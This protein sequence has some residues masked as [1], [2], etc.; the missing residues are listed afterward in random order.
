MLPLFLALLITST[1]I[2]NNANGYETLPASVQQ[3]LDKNT[4]NANAVTSVPYCLDIHSVIV[5]QAP[6]GKPDGI[7]FVAEKTTHYL[8][9]PLESTW[10]EFGNWFAYS[11]VSQALQSLEPLPT[12]TV[13]ESRDQ[14]THTNNTTGI[15]RSSFFN[16]RG[17]PVERVDR[18]PDPCTGNAFLGSISKAQYPKDIHMGLIFLHVLA[19]K[20]VSSPLGIVAGTQT[21]QDYFKAADSIRH[22]GTETVLNEPCEVIEILI[23]KDNNASDSHTYWLAKNLN[24]II[25]RRETTLSDGKRMQSICRE[26]QEVSANV[27]IGTDYC[28]YELSLPDSSLDPIVEKLTTRYRLGSLEFDPT[29][30]PHANEKDFGFKFPENSIVQSLLTTPP[31]S[32]VIGKD[33]DDV[34]FTFHRSHELERWCAENFPAAKPPQI[35]HDP[36]NIDP[37]SEAKPTINPSLTSRMA[38]LGMVSILFL[39]IV[40]WLWSRTRGVLS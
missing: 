37:E 26:W 34:L 8:N 30:W 28:G 22:L 13:M 17:A 18:F 40:I 35:P 32:L 23:S 38:I 25:L 21:F 29:K 1:P 15:I 4:A 12:A 16:S 31:S 36:V 33:L 39:M 3:L 24:G 7:P 19:P 6:A 10:R 27:F 2:S 11:D 5:Y 9:A 20:K 14:W